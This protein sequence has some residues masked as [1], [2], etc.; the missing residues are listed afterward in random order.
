[1]SAPIIRNSTDLKA[2]IFR[3]ERIEREKSV[4]LKAHFNSPAAIFTSVLSMV[5]SSNADKNKEGGIFS[6]DFLGL[7][8]RVLLPV[9][10]NKTIFRRSNFVVKTLVGLLSQKASHY[11]NEENVSGVW[12]K[13]SAAFQAGTEKGGGFF[14]AVKSFFEPK[15]TRKPVNY[16]ATAPAQQNVLKTNEAAQ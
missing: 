8:S 1:M 12:H 3:L 14:S 15:K 5:T 4:V 13:I 7:L 10:L 11:I 2:E 9:T 6:Q 16:P